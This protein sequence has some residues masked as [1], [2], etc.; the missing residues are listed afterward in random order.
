MKVVEGGFGK[1]DLKGSIEALT[2]MLPEMV[3]MGVVMAKI[4]AEGFSPEQALV[5]CQDIT[6]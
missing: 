4:R 6:L 5:L 2:R 1:N 3:A